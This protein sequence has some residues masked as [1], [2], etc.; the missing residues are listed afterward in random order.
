MSLASKLEFCSNLMISLSL[1]IKT[2]LS[3]KQV[4]VK[5][6]GVK[7]TTTEAIACRCHIFALLHLFFFLAQL[8][9]NR[10]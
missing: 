4:I 10:I 8:S 3:L 7:I 1:M 2:L 6:I 9:A 5:A